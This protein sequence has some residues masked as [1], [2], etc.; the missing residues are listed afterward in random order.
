MRNIDPTTHDFTSPQKVGKG[1]VK[2]KSYIKMTQYTRTLAEFGGSVD[3]SHLQMDIDGKVTL[4]SGSLL[5][6]EYNADTEIVTMFFDA[7]LSPEDLDSLENFLDTYVQPSYEPIA[8]GKFSEFYIN[9]EPYIEFYSQPTHSI[10][11]CYYYVGTNTAQSPFTKGY[12]VHNGSS[13]VG[14]SYTINI[15]IRNLT[16]QTIIVDQNV[17]G[18]LERLDSFLPI[19]LVSQIDAVTNLPETPSLFEVSYRLTSGTKGRIYIIH[20][21]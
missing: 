19:P 1:E 9:K 4:T 3:I 21:Y 5:N 18:S 7:E 17:T 20:V 10:L 13:K 2:L 11:A 12:I 15:K 6:V 14:L 8:D 16:E